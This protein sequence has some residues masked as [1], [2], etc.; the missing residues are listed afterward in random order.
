[1]SKMARKQAE[2]IGDLMKAFLLSTHLSS[3]LNTRRV[4]AAWDAASGAA[5]YTLKRFYRDGTLYI[6]VSSSVVRSQL[7][8]QK[9]LLVEKM[10]SILS[11]DE[12]FTREDT[13][14]GYLKNLRLK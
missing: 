10:N 13:R 14:V 5:Q 12:L 3:G 8:Y 4:F 6:T 1:M 9:D 2:P 7:E 11:E